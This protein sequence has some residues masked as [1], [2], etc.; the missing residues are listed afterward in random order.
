MA[1]RRRGGE[2][3]V[4]AVQALRGERFWRAFEAGAWEKGGWAP[5][6]FEACLCRSQTL[7]QPP[8]FSHR[9][10]TARQM[11]DWVADPVLYRIEYADGALWHPSLIPRP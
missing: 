9:R 3:G 11:R 6:L 10:P 2:R 5:E 8:T 4:R 1:E 7:A